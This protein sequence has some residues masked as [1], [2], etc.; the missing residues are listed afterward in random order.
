ML[1]LPEPDSAFLD[2]CAATPT[3]GL[4]CN[5][6]DPVTG[7]PYS[8]DPRFSAAKAVNYLKVTGI[9]DAVQ[10]GLSVQFFVFDRGAGYACR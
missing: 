5:V 8:R 7:E 4:V 1:L 9:A 6:Q 10:F 3:L 2:P